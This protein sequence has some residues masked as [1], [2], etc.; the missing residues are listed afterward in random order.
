MLYNKTNNGTVN[1]RGL[2][3]SIYR[4]FPKGLPIYAYKTSPKESNVDAF[5]ITTCGTVSYDNLSKLLTTNNAGKIARVS[6]NLYS[7]PPENEDEL[8]DRVSTHYKKLYLLCPIVLSDS[9]I[10]TS[11]DTEE[12]NCVLKNSNNTSYQIVTS[13]LKCYKVTIKNITII[14]SLEEKIIH[15]TEDCYIYKDPKPLVWTK[16]T[17][18]PYDDMYVY[19]ICYANNLWVV[20]TEYG[21]YYSE[22]GESWQQASI[23][24]EPT[25]TTSGDPSTTLCYTVTYGYVNNKSIWVATTSEFHFYSYDGKN[26]LCPGIG[27]DENGNSLSGI[28]TFYGFVVHFANNMFVAAGANGVY[29]STN[30]RDWIASN[31]DKN[32]TINPAYLYYANNTWV[33]LTRLN[34][35]SNAHGVY[36]STDGKT[37]TQSNITNTYISDWKLDRPIYYANGLWVNGSHAMNNMSPQYSTDGKTWTQSNLSYGHFSSI[38]FAN[39]TWVAGFRSWSKGL[40]YSTDGKTWTQSNIISGQI[41]TIYYA[42]N[43]W[44]AIPYANTDII[45]YSTDGKTWTQE[46]IDKHEYFKIRYVKGVWILCSNDGLY[47][48]KDNPYIHGNFN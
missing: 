29:Y 21:L 2:S 40:Y 8:Y 11:I 26:W 4:K 19:D 22:T 10:T 14:D 43:R 17:M 7:R 31:I 38:Y 32:S 20:A 24:F 3:D 44:V 27:Y 25:S 47:F 45:Y 13:T 23:T 9:T 37:W 33:L 39:N 30:G 34:S 18:T 46:T 28:P 5:A 41:S 6:L 48:A 42:N 15:P 1:I 16:C 35:T 36:Y 12:F